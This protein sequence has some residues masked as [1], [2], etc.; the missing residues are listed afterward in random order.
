MGRDRSSPARITM[1]SL[2]TNNDHELEPPGSAVLKYLLCG[3]D[4]VMMWTI[5]ETAG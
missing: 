5:E 3:P 4:G 2:W 1:F